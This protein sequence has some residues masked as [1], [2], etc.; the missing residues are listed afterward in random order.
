MKRGTVGDSIPV[1]IPSSVSDKRVHED[2]VS[3]PIYGYAGGRHRSGPR[4]SSDVN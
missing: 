2:S 4:V 1:L 3:P